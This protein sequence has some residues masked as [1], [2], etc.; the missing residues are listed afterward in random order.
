MLQTNCMG[1][2]AFKEI[3]TYSGSELT[4]YGVYSEMLFNE[5]PEYCLKFVPEQNY[6]KP[7]EESFEVMIFQ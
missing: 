3:K 1:F 7:T 5:K 4:S 2:C 6:V